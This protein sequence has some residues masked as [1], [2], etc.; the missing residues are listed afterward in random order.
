[1]KKSGLPLRRFFNTSG[2]LYK[3]MALKDKLPGMTDNEQYILLGEYGMLVKRPLMCSG[4]FCAGGFPRGG[5]V[6]SARLIGDIPAG[7]QFGFERKQALVKM[8]R[9]MFIRPKR[10]SGKHGLCFCAKK[11]PQNSLQA[12]LW[13][14]LTG[15][16]DPIRTDDL[17]ITSELLYRLSHTSIW[18]LNQ[19]P[20]SIIR[21]F[22]RSSSFF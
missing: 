22:L 12:V 17:L 16:G 2:L 9:T 19:V 7:V 11:N 3:G 14:F 13:V 21:N 10:V 18:R 1:M 15:A 6:C 5:M 20:L 4:R 8:F